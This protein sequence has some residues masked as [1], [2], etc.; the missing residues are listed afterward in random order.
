MRKIDI[1]PF[2]IP[3][4]VQLEDD[5]GQ[6]SLQWQN[7]QYPF[8]DNVV[9]I[10]LSA[11]NKLTARQLLER[12]MFCEKLVKA[13]REG[14]TDAM[15]EETEYGPVQSTFEDFVG[16]GR[17]DVEMVKRILEAPQ[18]AVEKLPTA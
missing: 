15:V 10:V 3:V 7:V 8:V 6:K 2:T 12:N 1:T 17:N 18:V 5:K 9:N 11:N 13:E 16:L 14:Q 4:A